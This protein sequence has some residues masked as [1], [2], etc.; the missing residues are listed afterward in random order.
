VHVLM[1]NNN[2]NSQKRVHTRRRR[3]RRRRLAKITFISY[4]IYMHMYNI[5]IIFDIPTTS[6]AGP[7]YGSSSRLFAILIC[8][9]CIFWR[10]VEFCWIQTVRCIPYA[11]IVMMMVD[12]NN[13][14]IYIYLFLTYVYVFILLLRRFHDPKK[15][16][17]ILLLCALICF[18]QIY[19]DNG[20]YSVV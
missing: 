7:L 9:K 14:R 1:F 4:I 18:N 20:R 12:D 11:I 3:R 17:Y 19:G 16:T 2:N 13:K 6:L 10:R 8:T 15:H 5:I